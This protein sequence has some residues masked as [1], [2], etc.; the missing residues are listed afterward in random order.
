MIRN[1]I[2]VLACFL[3]SCGML[4][5]Q[6]EPLI[7]AIHSDYSPLVA[8]GSNKPTGMLIDIWKLWSKRVNKEVIFRDFSWSDSIAA[9][10]IGKA[11]IHSGLFKNENFSQWID[12]S[13][14]FYE[15]DSSLFFPVT[16]GRIPNLNNLSDKM[17]GV[18]KGSFQEN[19][20]HTKYSDII[21]TPFVDNSNM[22]QALLK[23]KIKA[24]FGEN[25]AI[26]T[27]LSIMGAERKIMKVTGSILHNKIHAGVSKEKSDLI[28][29]INEGLDKISIDEL[30]EIESHW[31]SN[32]SLRQYSVPEIKRSISA[33][34]IAL[35]EKEKQWLKSHPKIKLGVDP[36]YPPFD[37][38]GQN[39]RH[40]GVASDFVH[41]LSERLGISIEMVTGLSWTQ[42]IKRSKNKSIDVL[43][44]VKKNEERSQYLNFT[45]TYI[46]NP[47]VLVT[48]KDYPKI[49]GL[50]DFKGKILAVVKGYDSS[51]R[52]KKN[53]PFIKLYEVDSPLEAL[54]A[55]AV[56]E[57]DGF[58]GIL[59]IVD[60]LISEHNLT[61][62][63]IASSTNLESPP[64]G[65]GIRKDWTELVSIFNKALNSITQK[66]RIQIYK[67][68]TSNGNPDSQSQE[69]SI[70]LTESE[71]AWLNNHPI[72]KVAAISNQSPSESQFQR[73][74]Y[75]EISL[76]IL[77]KI[78][79][80]T[81]FQLEPVFNEWH[82]HIQNLKNKEIDLIPGLISTSKLEKLTLFKS[83]WSYYTNGIIVKKERKG[84]SDFR[85]L[86]DKII[87]VEKDFY[88][89]DYY[90]KFSPNLTLHLADSSEEAIKSVANGQADAYIG[91]HVTTTNIIGRNSITNL[92]FVSFFKIDQSKLSIG[93]RNDYQ[94]L[95]S[96][97]QKGWE[98]ISNKEKQE[99][100]KAYFTRQHNTA[101]TKQY[102]L[103]LSEE[104]KSWLKANPK[105]IVGNK[106]DW[107]PFDFNIKGRE[108]GYSI[109]Y[110]KLLAKKRGIEL[111]F[112][113]GLGWDRLLEKFQKREIN[114]LP[115]IVNNSEL[116]HYIQ[117]TRSYFTYPKVLVTKIEET[118][119]RSIN[120]LAGKQLSI[121]KRY[122]DIKNFKISYPNV[123]LI[124]ANSVLEGLQNVLYGKSEAFIGNRTAISHSIQKNFFSGLNI[125]EEASSKH[126]VNSLVM[127]VQKNAPQLASILNKTIDSIT[128]DEVQT[129]R[130]KWIQPSELK[131]T[132]KDT[133]IDNIQIETLSKEDAIK[134]VALP[135][136][137]VII[138]MIVCTGGIF[139]IMN[140]YFKS[141]TTELFQSNKLFLIGLSMLAGFLL[142]VSVFTQLAI[143][144]IEKR[145]KGDIA[146]SLQTSLHSTHSALE[147]LALPLQRMIGQLSTEPR[148]I[149]LTKKQLKLPHFSQVLLQS[150][151]L[152][153][154]RN[155]IKEHRRSFENFNF[156]IIAPD[157]ISIASM[158]D[159]SIGNENLIARQRSELLKRAFQGETLLI[160]PVTEEIILKNQGSTETMRST[161][162]FAA[163]IKDQNGKILAVL[164]LQLK[165]L[166]AFARIFQEGQKVKN[167]EI[168][169]FDSSGFLASQSRFDDFIKQNDLLKTN[170]KGLLQIRIS[171]PGGN[172]IEGYQPSASRELQPLTTMAKSA[173]SGKTGVNV[174]GY[175][176]YLGVPVF[177]AWIWDQ[178]LGFGLA[179]E[180]DVA[181]GL[182]TF[183]TTRIIVISVL[184]LTIFISIALGLISML[185]ARYV[186]KILLK[187]RDELEDKVEERT[188]ELSL[189]KEDI[190]KAAEKIEDSLKLSEKLRKEAEAAS[191][192][193]LR[194]S[195]R[196][197][198]AAKEAELAK[199]EAESNAVKLN[200]SVIEKEIQNLE[201]EVAQKEEQMAKEEAEKNAAKLKISVKNIELKNIELAKAQTKAESATMAKSD[202]LANMSHEIRTPM[203]GILGMTF[204]CLQTDLSSRQ[205][206]YLEKVH[207]SATSLLGIINDI[208]DFSKI[209]A[210][211]MDMESINFDLDEVLENVATLI[212]F[213]AQDKGLEFLIK[214]P[215]ELPKLLIGDPLRL[216]QII[217]NLANNAVKFTKE[218]EVVISIQ[219]DHEENKRLT[220][221]FTVRDTGVGLT[222]DQRSKLFQSFSQADTSTTRKYGGTG[223]GL[224]ISKKIVEMMDGKIWV[225]SEPEKGSSF[226]FTAIFKRQ[227]KTKEKSFPA[228]QDLKGMKVLI[229]D[230]NKT[231]REI[232]NEILISFQFKT[233]TVPTGEKA[234][235][236]I[237][238][239]S[240]DPFELVIM[241]WQ[242]PGLNGVQTSVEIQNLLQLSKLPKIIM[243][244]SFDRE[245]VMRE[246]KDL[247]ISSFLTKPIN[248]SSLYDSIST[249]FGKD[250]RNAKRSTK[251]NFYDRESL[252]RI[253][254]ARILLAEDNEINQEVAKELLEGAGFI[255]D[256]AN[257]GKEAFNSVMAT[258]Y[259]VV[260]MDIQMPEMDGYESTKEIRKNLDFE[261]LP[262]IA[263]TANVMAG[264]RE[265]AMAVGMND[266]VA[267]PIDPNQLFSVIEKWIQPGER[268]IPST[269]LEAQQK[270]HTETDTLP[271]R[272]PG[273]ALSEGLKRMGGNEKSYRKLLY[274][275]RE[276]HKPFIYDIQ[277]AFKQK[278]FEL[279]E[280]L[281]HTLKGVSGNIGAQALHE[282]TKELESCILQKSQ[283]TEKQIESVQSHMSEVLN[284]IGLL[285]SQSIEATTDSV[286][287]IDLTLVTP[288][289]QQLSELLK[290]YDTDAEEL[291]ESLKEKF[292]QGDVKQQLEE[293]ENLIT[294]F[295]FEEAVE[296]LKKLQKSL[297]IEF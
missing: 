12:F 65:F 22:I 113:N 49:I 164:A 154:I 189:A 266:H 35:T 56:K 279:T 268:E 120:D 41:L 19:Y 242:M 58:A 37:F 2:L 4:T 21:V 31:V 160:L 63:Q 158:Q 50:D 231:A 208:L 102:L 149:T 10:Q 170:E 289:F 287:A 294:Q 36:H 235:E 162:F 151:Y 259:D 211:K 278:D 74:Q 213:K 217:I 111:E 206:N 47:I 114:I 159:T 238:K 13:Q 44:L 115:T 60:Y 54:K 274:K 142:I 221:K 230:D 118:D 219:L 55:I 34:N 26:D 28:N 245:E 51:S 104:E 187:S 82:N 78:A 29:I 204:L 275:F 185:S 267:K 174:K 134:Q 126:D 33:Q 292:P 232:L 15:I 127:G 155:F 220:L 196:A 81:G 234:I 83:P 171:D 282:A 244:T 141:F 216:G 112:V 45:N 251:I 5:A 272:L 152:I 80:Q 94:P 225:E 249:T 229:V 1:S 92:Q 30:V 135:A 253:R 116:D 247:E 192:R 117:P 91:P 131:E 156:F 260:L 148:L 32:I 161:M 128:L 143:N 248:P 177:G 145:V 124:P 215:V 16:D 90:K 280:R 210:G 7:I 129:L 283:K 107:A 137:L 130:K 8:T 205:K 184:G 163:P 201:L 88:L 233:K 169:S 132:Q 122:V 95:I 24:L 254:G 276:N 121:I 227:E 89:H 273:I 202:F 264:D 240:D 147:E 256:I 14:P 68:W 295:Q 271:D 40:Q 70:S 167:G 62:L 67:K 98:S 207:H 57:V 108:S 96:I 71:T 296:K 223:L 293:L 198:Q 73:N 18:V 150:P 109:E 39:G 176:N 52:L 153:G 228:Y 255:L 105:L 218:G 27:L 281:A 61:N 172:M 66:E 193:A 119:I 263:M 138:F 25:L 140:T 20:L 194:A 75:N 136:L 86:Q 237:R 270:S 190:E 165:Q 186:N 76:R 257:N 250:R 290:K 182:E 125:V 48:R 59:G 203:N 265:K 43:A 123:K 241:D 97:L 79:K 72:V 284:S 285:N 42:V 166:G 144:K 46:S 100:T 288:L 17:V 139:F 38:I 84:I 297:N 157:Y 85:N 224:S 53:Y 195:K 183:Y 133:F 87:A 77:Q 64:L 269:F 209:E 181:E 286:E 243:V 99:I 236:E 110:V 103:N 3:I 200:E 258:K 291:I 262:I 173:I 239:S 212:T 226:I 101:R 11:D 199:E 277:Q 23:G 146:T 222:T 93:I 246:A 69:T 179:K 197:R 180:I 214:A 9:L 168:Y 261:I 252:K 175:R 106:D 188:N 191:E 178:N 6:S